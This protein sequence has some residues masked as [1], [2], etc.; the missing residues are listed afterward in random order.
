MSQEVILLKGLPG[1]G[2]ST[3]AK[4]LIDKNPGKFKR[5][6][7][8]DLRAMLDNGKFSKNNEAFVLYMRNQMLIKALESTFSVIIDDTNLH[9][10]HENAI[11]T[12]VQEFNVQQGRG[13]NSAK[14]VINDSF[15]Q[16][17]IEE[18]IKRD[19]KRFNSVGKD[20]IMKMATE[21]GLLNPKEPKESYSRPNLP[22]CCIFDLD[23]TISKLNGRNPYDASTCE[24]DLPNLPVI[25]Y[26]KYHV[27]E[28]TWIFIFSGREDKYREQTLKW[29]AK[30]NLP[31]PNL[32]MRETGDLRKDSIIKK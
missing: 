28:G 6:N 26:L 24:N 5:I 20:V 23:G 11:R 32:V 25:E 15:L 12:I 21:A 13:K 2:K 18:C 3:Y 22:K 7:K 16:I 4:E 29:F 31:C 30:H 14:V 10:K 17:P 19:L 1:S 9:I 8:D 27:R